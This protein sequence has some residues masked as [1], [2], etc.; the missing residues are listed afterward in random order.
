MSFSLNGKTALVT[1]AANGVGQAIAGHFAAAGANV[2]MA[3]MDGAGLKAEVGG[4]NTEGSNI[5]TFAGD[6][7]EKLTIANLLSVTLDAFENVDILVNAARQVE[8]TSP[9]IP[10][11]QPWRPCWIKTC[12]PPTV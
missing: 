10:P 8:M 5:R 3:D 9:L 4:G 7:R 6:L 11:T 2:V 12:W 1:G